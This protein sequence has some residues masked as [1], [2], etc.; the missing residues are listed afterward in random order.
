MPKVRNV[1]GMLRNCRMGLMLMSISA[2]TRPTAAIAT[3]VLVSP[4]T[5]MPGT[6]HTAAPTAIAVASHVIIKFMMNLPFGFCA[7]R[8]RI[9]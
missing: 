6:I 3:H 1:M 9:Y 7:P 8:G 4:V 5:E 2:N